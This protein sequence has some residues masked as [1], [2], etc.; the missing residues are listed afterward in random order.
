MTE[1]Q[2]PYALEEKDGKNA[3]AARVLKI[4]AVLPAHALTGV[5][6]KALAQSLNTTPASISRAL[7]TLQAEGYAKRLDNGL[8]GP[9][10]RF[11]ALCMAYMQHTENIKRRAE[12]MQ[13]AA[14]ARAQH[15]MPKE[16]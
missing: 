4:L 9:S 10:V 11:L 2:A 8:W 1:T 7:A 14:F 13:H 12:E 15:Y 3:A 5:S 6:N 16:G